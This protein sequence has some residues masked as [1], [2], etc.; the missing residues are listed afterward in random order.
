MHVVWQQEND[1]TYLLASL[2]W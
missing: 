2:L 1:M